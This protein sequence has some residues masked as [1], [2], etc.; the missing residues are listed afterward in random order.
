MPACQRKIDQLMAIYG[1]GQQFIPVIKK[2]MI[3]RG[4]EM[5]PF[6]AQPMLEADERETEE[7]RKILKQAELL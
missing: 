6:C 1:V 2:A 7:I 4:M 5:E 3:L